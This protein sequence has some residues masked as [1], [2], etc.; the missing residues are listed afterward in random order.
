MPVSLVQSFGPRNSAS[1]TAM[2]HLGW[3]WKWKRT[4]F[5]GV[6]VDGQWRLQSKYLRVK[7]G[8]PESLLWT[9]CRLNHFSHTVLGILRDHMS[10]TQESPCAFLEETNQ[11]FSTSEAV[12]SIFRFGVMWTHVLPQVCGTHWSLTCKQINIYT[13]YSMLNRDS[14]RKTCL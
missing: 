3:P 1:R 12:R 8:K 9:L 2:R 6:P 13:V 14:L 10:L 7:F 4:R 11:R 5:S